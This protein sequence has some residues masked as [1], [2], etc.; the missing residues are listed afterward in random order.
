LFASTPQPCSS[1]WK[2]VSHDRVPS[3]SRASTRRRG[4]QG[5]GR[6]GVHLRRSA[7]PP[8]RAGLN[9]EDARIRRSDSATST[10]RFDR[11]A[12]RPVEGVVFPKADRA[13]LNEPGGS[14]MVRRPQH[15]QGYFRITS[16]I[17]PDTKRDALNEFPGVDI[18]TRI[19][20]RPALHHL[21]PVRR[22]SAARRGMSRRAA[23]RLVA[24][25]R[26]REVGRQPFEARALPRPERPTAG[27]PPGQAMPE[28]SSDT[29]S[30][31]VTPGV[32][33][34]TPSPR[35]LNGWGKPGRR[36]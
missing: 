28:F 18:E 25:E 21:I 32:E 4:E 6:E 36:T 19:L 7:G 31:A 3:N 30:C 34:G 22:L 23:G 33:P 2:A 16:I 17:L 9:S 13:D 5:T 26:P 11:R 35:D 20:V 24:R 29:G 15:A 14:S 8:R 12:M 27:K 1:M 10:G